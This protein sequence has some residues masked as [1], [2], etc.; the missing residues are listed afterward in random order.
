LATS[1]LSYKRTLQ[2]IADLLSFENN[3]GALRLQLHPTETDWESLVKVA[4]DHLVLTT[5][6]CR[7][8][9][10]QLLNFLPEDLVIYLNEL[11]AINRNRN[12]TLLTEIQDV[13][14]LFDAHNI[15]H[16]F[17]KGCALLAGG[18]YKDSGERMIGDM[19]ILVESEQIE[20]AFEIITLQGYSK[21][22]FFNY[23][24]QNFRHLDRQVREDKLAAIE[25]HKGVLND[26]YAH[27][28]DSNSILSTKTIVNGVAIPNQDNLIWSTILAH[29]INNYGYYY[30][31]LNF[32]YVYDC[33]VLKL[34][35]E[36][37]RLKQ[38]YQDRYCAHFLVLARVHFPEIAI[39]NTSISSRISRGYYVFTINNKR[40][41]KVLF[42]I[43]SLLRN[44]SERL[45]LIIFNTSYRKHILTNKIFKRS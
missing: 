41:G 36:K 16:V 1:T 18:Y 44:I 11:T 28:M 13:S 10:K 45:R 42:N 31:S 27:L 21:S 22:I 15:N 33:L 38:L 6:Y 9:Q 34:V 26:R 19:D 29:Q 35:S 17:L 12:L 14:N 5:V 30:N 3:V 37:P 39:F 2:L 24:V 4:S 25:L 7:L 20:K 40:L 8:Q 32:K 23:D 43:K